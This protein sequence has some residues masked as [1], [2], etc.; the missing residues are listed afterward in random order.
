MNPVRLQFPC[1]V[2]FA[3]LFLAGCRATLPGIDILLVTPDTVDYRS[4]TAVTV[5]ATGNI[6]PGTQVYLAPGGPHLTHTFTD[7]GPIDFVARYETRQHKEII[8][9]A[10]RAGRI[11]LLLLDNNEYKAVS[12]FTTAHAINRIK[13]Y[14]NKLLVAV[15]GNGLDVYNIEDDHRLTLAQQYKTQ[16]KLNDIQFDGRNLYLLADNRFL[17]TLD[18]DSFHAKTVDTGFQINSIAVRGNYCYAVGPEPGLGVFDL[19]ADPDATLKPLDSFITSGSGEQVV[20]RDNLA[21]IA[22]GANGIVVFDIS[23]PDKL[24][25]HGSHNKIGN[26]TSLALNGDIAIVNNDATRLVSLNIRNTELPVTGSFFK[27]GSAVKNFVLD[28][29][30]VFAA[31][32][33]GLQRIDFSV[34]AKQQISDEGINL[35]G[36][37]RAFIK[38]NIAYVADWFSG[39]HLY[40]ISQPEQPRHLGN[41]HTPGSSKGVVVKDHYAI[42][43]DDDHGLQI[44]DVSNP[45]KP[46]WVTEL[47]STGLAYTMKL[48]GDRLYLADHRGGFHIIDVSDITH[49]KHLAVWDTSGKSWAIDVVGNT[50]YVADDTSGLLVFDVSNPQQIKQLGQFNPGGQAEDVLVRDGIAYVAF[51][52]K[53][54][55][56]LDVGNP[57]DPLLS[58]HLEIP[59]NARSIKIEDRAGKRYGYIAGW[60]SGLQIVD[61]SDSRKPLIVGHIDTSGS[62]WGAD[63]SGDHAFV[64]DWWGGVR[65]VDI[66]DP[67]RPVLAGKYQSHGSIEKLSIHGNYMFSANGSGGLQVFDINN[68]LNPIWVTGIDLPGHAQDVSTTATRA[69]VALGEAGIAVLDTGRPFYVELSGLLATGHPV[70]KVRATDSAIYALDDQGSLLVVDARDMQHLSLLDTLALRATD[71]WLADGRLYVSTADKT[72]ITYDVNNTVAPQLIAKLITDKPW[73]LVRAQGDTVAVYE[74]GTGIHLLSRLQDRLK[75][76]STVAS[77]TT[78]TDMALLDG[79]LM[80]YSPQNGLLAVDIR[81]LATPVITTLYP[82]TGSHDGFVVNGDAAFFSGESTIASTDML[83]AQTTRSLDST[84]LSVELP[85]DMPLGFYH[86]LLN[87]PEGQSS[88]LGNAIQVRTKQRKKH[89]FSIEDFQKIMEQ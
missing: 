34:A 1:A 82:A 10:S 55:Y 2:A 13:V 59:G 32:D 77:K 69:V 70:K 38:D 79:Q 88:Q 80:I 85:G 53:G 89:K 42:V 27:T 74:K 41:Y 15:N 81:D 24:R 26:V 63:I 56:L 47:L 14:D 57:S 21:W 58:S 6:P 76:V 71:L 16:R 52:D 17:I 19:G 7:S 31:T 78:V 28:D 9:T 30:I 49:P 66:K 54:L 84:R 25:W 61:V 23:Q 50:A 36:S 39:L 20:L 5:T 18:R 65:V 4:K 60:E 68:P 64:W 8:I 46:V 45:A 72:L 43:A 33:T 73:S 22:D 11:R 35:G 29:L 83:P 37:R 67:T 62:A 51:F 87:P 3:A 48:V 75:T 86:L 40:E 12:A 44:V